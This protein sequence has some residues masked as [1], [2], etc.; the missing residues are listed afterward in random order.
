MFIYIH[1]TAKYEFFFNFLQ[2]FLNFMLYLTWYA[3]ILSL[4]NYQFTSSIYLAYNIKK[5]YGE[6]EN[7]AK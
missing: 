3:I 1:A 2:I 7:E 4:F 5:A 6:H